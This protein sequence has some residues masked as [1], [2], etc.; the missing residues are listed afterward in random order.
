[1]SHDLVTLRV[2]WNEV[3]ANIAASILRRENIKVYLSG[4]EIA[5]M[6]W[7]LANAIG[8]IRLQVAEQDVE[9]SEELLEL[10]VSEDADTLQ[11][12]T[13]ENGSGNPDKADDHESN[14]D[15]DE[16]PDRYQLSDDAARRYEETLSL[17]EQKA[18]Y[19]LRSATIGLLFIPLQFYTA[20]LIHEVYTLEGQL[21][22]R[23]VRYTWVACLFAAPCL[24]F[25]GIMFAKLLGAFL[26]TSLAD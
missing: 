14:W 2:F 20:Y 16:L 9:R 11:A 13:E 23:Y 12:R 22:S 21:R 4:G 5:S 18:G 15:E 24:M 17:R 3:E 6:D 8:G 26:E 25:M 19:A 1:M 7:T 10:A